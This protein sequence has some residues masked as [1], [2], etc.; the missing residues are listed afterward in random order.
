MNQ[1]ELKVGKLADAASLVALGILIPF[2]ITEFGEDGTLNLSKLAAMKLHDPA[3]WKNANFTIVAMKNFCWY[4]MSSP[5]N[6]EAFPL[7]EPYDEK[8]GNS[9]YNSVEYGALIR[10]GNSL[11]YVRFRP[12]EPETNFTSDDAYYDKTVMGG[13]FKDN[14][15]VGN[16]LA[17][18]G[19]NVEKYVSRMHSPNPPSLV[20]GALFD[21]GLWYFSSISCAANKGYSSYF[22]R[23][24][25]QYF[26]S[27]HQVVSVCEVRCA[28]TDEQ[29]T[30]TRRSGTHE[31]HIVYDPRPDHEPSEESLASLFTKYM[32]IRL[33]KRI[34]IRTI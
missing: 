29:G 15:F 17:Q 31:S 26:G 6:Q 2:T 1:E 11:K 16:T 18:C 27:N 7:I 33:S 32:R 13:I 21:S 14:Q 25:E 28:L 9:L 23:D 3:N 20:K 4:M 30:N 24:A 12:S 8:K 22:I 19:N 34:V 5:K 10:F